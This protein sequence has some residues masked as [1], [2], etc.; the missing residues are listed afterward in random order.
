MTGT[1]L[2]IDVGSSAL[3]AVL[4]NCAGAML[5]SS[6]RP[7]RTLAGEAERSQEQD[8]DAWWRA[9]V[10]ALGDF[11]DRGSVAALVF[12]GSMQNL[13]VCDPDGTPLAPAFLYSDRRLDEILIA[14]LS[15]RLPDDYGRRTGNKLDP[16]HTILKLMSIES[17]VPHGIGSGR[18]LFG[19]KDALI[20]RLTGRATVDPTTAST[21]GLMR[22]SSRIWDPELIAA[23]G[24]DSAALPEILAGDEIVGK[25]RLNQASELGLPAGIPVFNGAGD[26]AGA[27]WGAH[28][29]EP[30]SA[31]AYLGT[32]GWVAATLPLGK[33]DPPRD[34]YTL[35]DP[36]HRDRVIII[37][38]F[39][40]AGAALEWAAEVTGTKIDDLLMAA[41]DI[42]AAPPG[43]LFLPYL[44]GERSPFE[45]QVVR[46][47]FLGL[48]HRH[49]AGELAYAVMEGIAFAIRHNLDMA[50]LP[51]APLTLIGGGARDPTQCQ[52]LADILARDIVVLAE[53]RETTAFGALRMVARPLG[54][55]LD[56]GSAA[57]TV[58][59]PRAGRRERSDRRYET[60]LKASR[61]VRDCASALK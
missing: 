41:P 18:L 21:T 24:I 7:I 19:A 57:G 2:A 22:I 14:E 51:M 4:F 47:A 5:A 42:D 39:L 26:A 31:Y 6:S 8:V 37:S 58:V 55:T 15:R 11:Q 59:S 43:V 27:S 12:T 53:S 46:G 61:F 52:L 13:I 30:G 33:A 45:D 20:L 9:L 28:A 1:I 44:R 17:F 40:T 32:T 25:L 36:V 3:K 48:D 49:G 10:S 60:Y 16:A 54:L 23:A 29:D 35:A 50:D 38:P 56:E 34:I